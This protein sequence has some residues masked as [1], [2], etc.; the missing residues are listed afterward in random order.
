M[1]PKCERPSGD[2]KEGMCID[3]IINIVACTG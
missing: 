3:L 1:R 2:E